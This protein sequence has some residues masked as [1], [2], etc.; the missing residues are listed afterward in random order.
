MLVKQ[1]H[2]GEAETQKENNTL[3][4][5]KRTRNYY[6][7]RGKKILCNKQ[8][9]KKKIINCTD[10]LF[11]FTFDIIKEDVWQRW[12][13]FRIGNALVNKRHHHNS[14]NKRKQHINPTARGGRNE[15]EK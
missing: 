3:R 4:K 12:I 8:F 2:N 15:M 7:R 10:F 5:F 11:C 6:K 1:N 14:Q 9:S 13:G